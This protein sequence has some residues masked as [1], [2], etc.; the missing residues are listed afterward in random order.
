MYKDPHHPE[1]AIIGVIRGIFCYYEF[2]II[3]VRTNSDA[4]EAIHFS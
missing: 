1:S 4:P 2:E 3:Y